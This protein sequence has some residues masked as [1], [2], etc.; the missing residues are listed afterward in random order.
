MKQ[1]K[2][3]LVHKLKFWTGS[4]IWSCALMEAW[5]ELNFGGGLWYDDIE[6]MHKFQHIWICLACTSFTKF[7]S[8]QKLWKIID[9]PSAEWTAPPCSTH[10]Q[11]GDVSYALIQQG[12]RERLR[13]TPSSTT[14]WWRWWCSTDAG[15]RLSTATILSRCN[16]VE[17]G[18]AHG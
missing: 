14:A 13:K 3:Y 5:N 11:P 18:T 2:I 4:K 17:G 15:L 9:D 8:G 1:G 10:V 12:G 7:L 16:M 6:V